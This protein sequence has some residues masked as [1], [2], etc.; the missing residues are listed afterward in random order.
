MHSAAPSQQSSPSPGRTRTRTPQAPQI[1]SDIQEEVRVLQDKYENSLINISQCLDEVVRLAQRH[2]K[3]NN[4]TQ[5]LELFPPGTRDT[6]RK[7]LPRNNIPGLLKRLADNER[8][9]KSLLQSRLV[10]YSL[11]EVVAA[12]V[13]VGTPRKEGEGRGKGWAPADVKVAQEFLEQEERS[14]SGSDAP[15][16]K[17]IEAV[18][19]AVI[20][21]DQVVQ[22]H[23]SEPNDQPMQDLADDHSPRPATPQPCFDFNEDYRDSSIATDSPPVER[24]RRTTRFYERDLQ[25]DLLKALSDRDRES[26]QSPLPSPFPQIVQRSTPSLFASSPIPSNTTPR[27]R[28]PSPGRQQTPPVYNLQEQMEVSETEV[29]VMADSE[30][31]ASKVEPTTGDFASLSPG[32]WLSGST[33]NT[34]LRLL[35]GAA[36]FS[37]WSMLPSDVDVA[38]DGAYKADLEHS[39]W[40]LVPLNIDNKH[41]VLLA[42]KPERSEIEVFDSAPEPFRK[43]DVEASCQ[44]LCSSHLRSLFKANTP[45]VSYRQALKQADGFNCGVYTLVHAAYLLLG[46]RFPPTT[47]ANVWRKAF[48]SFNVAS[49]REAEASAW[50]LYP[51]LEEEEVIVEDDSAFPKKGAKLGVNSCSASSASS[52]RYMGI[53]RDRLGQLM[54]RNL[55]KLTEHRDDIGEILDVVQ[56]FLASVSPEQREEEADQLAQ[57]GEAR[58]A[59]LDAMK[60]IRRPTKADRAL[61]ERQ[62]SL[63]RVYFARSAWIRRA[64][65]AMKGAE[66]CLKLELED[67]AKHR[68]GLVDRR[69]SPFFADNL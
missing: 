20:D 16:S 55:A 7:L 8:F 47:D 17:N 42:I 40:L 41:W 15:D 4:I 13:A 45:K 38:K 14:D 48:N 28:S 57:E 44:K 63:K 67:V 22:P 18:S 64:G 29:V 32:T 59:I 34:C 24:P 58:T 61:E 43:G 56:E 1:T 65:E 10:G 52:R 21:Q 25:S 27:P 46:R 11:D 49:A 26:T 33:M 31:E 51:E 35:V 5:I 30:L 12:L 37:K 19:A 60:G 9:C 54:D 23:H 66:D 36:C 62:K 2:E 39:T 6:L 3:A 53:L 50:K 69:S 68:Q